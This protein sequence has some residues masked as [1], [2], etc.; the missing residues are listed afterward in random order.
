M[1][2]PTT[3]SEETRGAILSQA[4]SNS[5]SATGQAKREKDEEERLTDHPRGSTVE[6][7][8]APEGGDF[9]AGTDAKPQ[10]M[11]TEPAAF[12]PSGTIPAAMV[13]SPGGFVPLSAIPEGE[14]EGRL[15]STLGK[16]PIGDQHEKLTE[17]EL[18]QLDGPSIRAIAVQRG[19]KNIPEFGSRTIRSR[20]LQEQDNDPLF[21]KKPAKK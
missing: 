11:Q 18:G 9:G 12:T 14:R 10:G 5:A 3:Q 6:I 2:S 16:Q 4:P 21:E 15:R 13:S 19:Y 1:T 8:G 17:E 20:F 7:E